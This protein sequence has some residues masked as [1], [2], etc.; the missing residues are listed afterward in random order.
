MPRA[1][2]FNRNSWL[3]NKHDIS[4]IRQHYESDPVASLTHNFQAPDPQA[5][6]ECS[7]S[8]HH[9]LGPDETQD[10]SPVSAAHNSKQ[11]AANVGQSRPTKAG[12]A[13]VCQ[14]TT[15]PR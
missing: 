15:G 12:A 7:V 6:S 9:R 2:K 14:D 8:S 3:F 11:M 5:L 13:C 4:F 1:V 10:H